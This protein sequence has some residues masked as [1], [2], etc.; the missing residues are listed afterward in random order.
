MITTVV[1]AWVALALLLVALPLAAWWLGGRRFWGRLTPRAEPDLYRELVRRHSLSPGEAATVEGAVTWGR[2]LTDP[3]LRA[4]VVDW[5]RSGQALARE[6]SA[7]H[8]RA[9]RVAWVLLG[10][11]GALAVAALVRDVLDEGWVVLWDL[12]FWWLV[13]L[14][15]ATL[16]ARGPRRAIERNSGPVDAP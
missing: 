8:P 13:W 5:A 15:P 12:P 6:R 3:R 10:L 1:V 2:E 9:A 4:A 14:V 11:I 7:R 16:M